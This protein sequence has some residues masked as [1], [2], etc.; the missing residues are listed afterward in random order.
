MAS[1]TNPAQ[2]Q[3]LTYLGIE[4]TAFV[5]AGVYQ[6]FARVSCR[7]QNCGREIEILSENKEMPLHVECPTH[8]ELAVFENFAD[9]AETLKAAINQS[10]DS[11][12]LARIDPDAEG[13]FERYS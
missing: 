13:I 7:K 3:K 1:Q 2:R 4:V 11:I 6:T 12:G 8:G 5:Q 9:Y 10:N